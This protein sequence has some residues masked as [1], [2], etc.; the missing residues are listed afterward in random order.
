MA[1]FIMWRLVGAVLLLLAASAAMYALTAY[2]ADPLEDLQTLAEP[3]RSRQIEA[4]SAALDLDTPVPARYLGWLG[5][6]GRCLLP[7]GGDCTMGNDRSGLAVLPQLA[8]AIEVT[9]RLVLLSVLVSILLGLVLGVL[10]ALRESS[11]FDHGLTVLAFL[12][13][14]LPVFWLAALLKEFLAIRFNNWLTDPRASLWALMLVAGCFG[15][16]TVAM[17]GRHRRGLLAGAGTAVLVLAGSWWLLASGWFRTPGLGVAGVGLTTVAGSVAALGLTDTIRERIPR[18]I[19]VAG[20]VMTLGAYVGLAL[21][22]EQDSGTVW[23][24]SCIGLGV[25]L[26]ALGALIFRDS[27]GLGAVIGLSVVLVGHVAIAVDLVLRAYPDYFTLTRGRVIPTSGSS[28]AGLDAGPWM[29]VLDLA[30]HLALPTVAMAA[31]SIAVYTRYVRA[32]VLE[33]IH[34]D[35]V[36]TA[37]AKGLPRHVVL[38]RHVLRTAAAPIATLVAFDLAAVIGGSFIVE[39]LFG[40][41]GGMGMFFVTAM[42][43]VD[44]N[45]IMALFLLSSGAVVLANLAADISYAVLDPR[46]RVR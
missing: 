12:C 34:R 30:V 41:S 22:P 9:L 42:N 3:E 20:T 13:L 19:A 32:G 35:Y 4:R 43:N 14:S 29:H 5:E 8:P 31:V 26:A 27:R 28:L 7:V 38:T 25:L 24:I 1:R 45:P 2:S 11:A 17:V 37:T 6:V 36:R 39:T 46:V 21:L 15:V 23:W 18:M 16:V 10:V 33:V 40:W 44:L